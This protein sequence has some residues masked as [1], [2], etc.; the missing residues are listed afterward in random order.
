MGWQECSLMDK[1]LKL[2]A[3]LLEGSFPLLQ[4]SAQ[5]ANT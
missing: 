3:R 4:W 2:I 1:S 5:F